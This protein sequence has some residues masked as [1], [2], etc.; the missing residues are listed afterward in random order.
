MI[1]CDSSLPRRSPKRWGA[2][3]RLGA[4]LLASESLA[5]AAAPGGPA[6]LIASTEPG[7]PQF[8]GPRRDGVSDERGLLPTWP[9]AGP[10]EL[11][12]AKGVGRGFS[13]PIIADGRLFLAGDFAEEVHVL[14]FD[15]QGKPLWQSPNGRSWMKQYPGARASV[16]YSAGRVY[17]YSGQ[18]RLACFEAASGREVWAV[19]VLTRFRGENL[20]WGLS[21]CVVVDGGAVYVTAG[22][23]DALIVAFDQ[24]TGAVRWQSEPLFDQEGD[25]SLETAGYGSPI[26]VQFAGRRLLIGCTLRYLIC[27]DA[28]TG[29]LQW[30]QRRPTSY[31]VQA[32]MPVLVG[33][34]VFMSAPYGPPGR[35]YRL[36]APSTPGGDIG[37]E[38]TWSTKLDTCQGGV[39][40]VAGRLYGSYYPGR[41]GWAA[42]DATTGEVLYETADFV[43]GAV[44]A[45]DQRLYALSEDGWMLLLQPGASQFE[46][47][48]KFRLAEARA[49]DAWAHPV[50]HD[51]RLYL[52]YH[53]TLWCYEVRA[54]TGRGR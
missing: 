35:L 29:K 34:A 53:D 18:G 1:R 37:V 42:L 4:T 22:G 33:D 43:K 32:M 10:K 11:W 49:R 19:D 23:K 25:G 27:T 40:H 17:H 2:V 5:W 15:L 28:D 13:A 9:E 45:A 51:G 14:A 8:R 48:G 16:T 24:M 38:E 50:I 21:E 12:S 31:S 47:K 36:L 41:K 20:T 46:V 54:E 3:W 6:A 26:L 52:R 44:L 7:W 30:K 39:V